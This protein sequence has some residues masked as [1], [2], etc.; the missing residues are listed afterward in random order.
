MPGMLQTLGGL[1]GVARLDLSRVS[2]ERGRR[3]VY[4]WPCYFLAVAASRSATQH[5]GFSHLSPLYQNMNFN[6]KSRVQN[7]RKKCRTVS[8]PRDM[9]IYVV[10]QPREL[11]SSC[12][13]A[14]PTA[15]HR[16]S[17]RAPS[18]L[19]HKASF[20]DLTGCL[21]HC[22]FPSIFR[23][24]SP[25][26]ATLCPCSGPLD[27]SPTTS[28]VGMSPQRLPGSQKGTCSGKGKQQLNGDSWAPSLG[29]RQ[30]GVAEN[31][32]CPAVGSRVL[33]KSL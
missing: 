1:G 27:P 11:C 29:R 32:P 12:R 9:G 5:A 4:G 16:A 6:L 30:E 18:S 33:E 17:L 24:P 2:Q 15:G 28:S 23:Q 14:F 25:S 31:V 22:S 21:C 26:L 7:P 19:S 8:F 3:G 20:P 13:V 10:L